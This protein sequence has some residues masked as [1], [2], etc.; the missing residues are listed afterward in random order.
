LQDTPLFS[1]AGE[2]DDLLNLERIGRLHVHLLPP[3]PG[4]DTRWQPLRPDWFGYRRLDRPQAG[5]QAG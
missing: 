5:A 3:Q 1:G 4:E 2:L